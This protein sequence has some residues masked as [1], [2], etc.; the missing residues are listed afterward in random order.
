[1]RCDVPSS[2]VDGEVVFEGEEFGQP[3]HLFLLGLACIFR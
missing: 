2:A 3:L 1:M